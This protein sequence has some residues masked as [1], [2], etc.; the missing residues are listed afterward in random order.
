MCHSCFSVSIILLIYFQRSLPGDYT[1]GP[2]GVD[3]VE[4]VTKTWEYA[5]FFPNL[6]AYIRENIQNKTLSSLGVRQKTT[7][8]LVGWML[9]REDGSLGMLHVHPDH[10][11]KGIGTVLIQKLS[12]EVLTQREA[13]YVDIE[14]GNRKPIKLYERCGYEI[15]SA[16]L[17]WINYKPQ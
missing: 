16:Q 11:G 15:D 10:R 3:K 9:E 4:S 5:S 2:L 8:Q 7:G 13:V 1:S 6:D 12:E 17:T 14:P